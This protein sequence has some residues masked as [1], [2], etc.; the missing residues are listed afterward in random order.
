MF[1]TQAV[2]GPRHGARCHICLESIVFDCVSVSPVKYRWNVCLP[3]DWALC[4][5]VM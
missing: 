5:A 1:N 3:L 4:V 2:F